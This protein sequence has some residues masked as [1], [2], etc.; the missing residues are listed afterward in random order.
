MI[1]NGLQSFVNE[2][3]RNGQLIRIKQFVNPV[4]EITEI[5]DR[6][7]KKTSEQNKALLFENTGT[8]FPLLI[9][10]LGTVQRMC[11]ALNIKELDDIKNQ[12]ESLFTSFTSPKITLLDKLRMLPQIS[13]IASWMPKTVN[14]NAPC[15]EVIMTEPDLSRLPILQCWKHDGG[16]FITFPVVITKDPNT[17]I[18]NV[19]MYR[20]QVFDNQTTG[21]HWHRH[22]TGAR[23][24]AEYKRLG[25]QMPVAVILGGDPA[26]TYSATAPLPDNVDE[27][28]FAGFLRKKKVEMVRC[29]TQ[30]IDIP[31]DA[32]FV[33]EGYVDPAEELAWE[34]PFGDHTGFYSL[35]DWY[36]RFHVTCISHRKQAIYPATIVGIP[37]QEDAAIA[38]A[39]ERIFLAPIRL[40][41]LP[42]MVNM[43][44][45]DVGVA[46]NLTLVSIEKTFPAQAIKVASTLWGAGQMMFNKVLVVNDKDTNLHNYKAL[47]QHIS[48]TIIPASDIY[49]SKGPLDV[50]DHTSQKFSFGGK[51]CIDAT[52]KFSEE[53]TD[54][55]NV[56]YKNINFSKDILKKQFVE[57]SEIN[58]SLLG[59][60]ISLIIISFRKSKPN[61]VR[62]LAENLFQN[63]TLAGIK[64]A[65]FVDTE[66][67]IRDIETTLWLSLANFDAVRDAF[68]I[69]NRNTT[70]TSHLIVDGTRKTKQYDG[71]ERI[72]P[73]IVVS[74]DATIQKINTLWAS[75]GIGDFVA[76]PSLKYKSL[77]VNEG[78]E[79]REL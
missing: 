11:I 27:F 26:Y 55:Q 71:F 38:R 14:R 6:I 44:I 35:A 79:V 74:D 64:C 37:P 5:V 28:M 43:N 34:G 21:M 19:G 29:L 59:E 75:L 12:I 56:S 76:S 22:K 47:A 60:S 45:P 50:L 49:F 4:L 39:T 63:E 33:I 57:I 10:A 68:V 17:G 77:V 36:P 1:Y 72:F 67:D 65:I 52:Q 3:E 73:N 61:R 58:D 54:I 31:I 7:S 25:K 53:I 66:V 51:M 69:D 2:L 20:M 32:D 15:Q 78:A 40:A 42:E 62:F 41:L 8:G 46:H 23:H 70:K 13:Q 48:E 24:Y 9:N 18:R 30:D 16:R